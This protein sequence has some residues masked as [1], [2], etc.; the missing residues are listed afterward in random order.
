MIGGKTHMERQKAGKEGRRVRRW[1]GVRICPVVK[2]L[3]SVSDGQT[4][5]RDGQTARRAEGQTGRDIACSYPEPCSLAGLNMT[6]GKSKVRIAEICR[7]VAVPP[8]DFRVSHVGS[9]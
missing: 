1:T 7:A 3:P 2:F 6:G 4:A 8:T 9:L 5:R